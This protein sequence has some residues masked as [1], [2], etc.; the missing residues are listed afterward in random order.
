MK[1][2][3]TYLCTFRTLIIPYFHIIL[4]VTSPTSHRTFLS[5][6]ALTEG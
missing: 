1:T 4:I 6:N 2:M 3:N 5:Q